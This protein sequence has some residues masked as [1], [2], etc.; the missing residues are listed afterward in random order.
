MAKRPSKAAEKYKRKRPTREPYDVVLIVCEGKKTEPAYFNGIRLAYRLSSANVTAMQSGQGNDPM[1]VVTYAEKMAGSKKYDKVYCVFDRNGHAQYAAAIQR[2][3]QSPLAKEGRLFA[4]QSVPCFELWIL[5]HFQPWTAPFTVSGGRSACE[6]AI[7]E[8]QRYIPV[9]GKN[10]AGVFAFLKD[11][12]DAAVTNGTAL[13]AHN[14]NTGSDNPS[15]FVH[16][17]LEC[18]RGLRQ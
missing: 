12:L 11:R 10:F 14:A 7:R 16:K 1:S 18:L 3:I 13:E 9:Y 4:A 15:T 8:L 2:V 17:L 6:N 5:L